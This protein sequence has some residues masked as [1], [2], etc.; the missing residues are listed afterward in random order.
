MEKQLTLNIDENIIKKAERYAAHHQIS[1][2]GLVKN[3]LAALTS[4]QAGDYEITPL[5]RS[6]SGVVTL[7]GDFDYRDAYAQHLLKKHS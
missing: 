6:L 7:P 2:E 3:Y 5:I 4:E 1:I